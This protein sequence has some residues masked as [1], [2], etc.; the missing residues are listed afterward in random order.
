[1]QHNTFNR[2]FK[3]NNTMQHNT[4][5][6]TFKKEKKCNITPSTNHLRKTNATFCKMQNVFS[7]KQMKVLY[8]Q[9]KHLRKQEKK[10]KRE[11]GR[12]WGA[13]FLHGMRLEGCSKT[14]QCFTEKKEKRRW[15][16]RERE[17]GGGDKR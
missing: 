16:G 2:S 12:G 13:D 17:R 8:L 5:N 3:K 15:R 14:L 9:Q 1:M 10:K 11:K 7:Q 4:F 6:R